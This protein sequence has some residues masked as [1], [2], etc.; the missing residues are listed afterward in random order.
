MRL[1]WIYYLHYYRNVWRDGTQFVEKVSN[2]RVAVLVKW[3]NVQTDA[4]RVAN[5][6]DLIKPKHNLVHLCTTTC[7]SHL[8]AAVHDLGQYYIKWVH[9]NHSTRVWKLFGRPMCIITT[10]SNVFLILISQ[11][12]YEQVLAPRCSYLLKLKMKGQ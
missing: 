4:P 6:A 12:K 1:S 10:I 9:D 8:N 2:K 5:Y 7:K 11:L 3:Y